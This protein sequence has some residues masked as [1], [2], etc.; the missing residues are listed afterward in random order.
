LTLKIMSSA[1]LA[2]IA[3]VAAAQLAPSKPPPKPADVPPYI[4]PLSFSAGFSDDAVFQRGEA[5]HK[6]YGFTT[7]ASPI[8][9][10]VLSQPHSLGSSGGSGGGGG[11]TVT[12]TVSHWVSTSGCNATKCIDPK[13]PLPTQHGGYT[14]VAELHPTAEPGGQYTV[15]ASKGSGVNET[16]TLERVTYGDVYFCSGQSNMAGE[17]LPHISLG[18][19]LVFCSR[20]ARSQFFP[21]GTNSNLPSSPRGVASQTKLRNLTVLRGV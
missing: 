3:S 17:P 8:T 6:V 10:S 7:D 20:T 18:F 9:V 1:F 16:I 5:G 11:Y 15:S 13:T 14:W 12:A 4:P 2:V 19:T 21:R